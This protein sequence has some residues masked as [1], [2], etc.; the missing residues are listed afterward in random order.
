M[1]LLLIRWGWRKDNRLIFV[2]CLHGVCAL[3]CLGGRASKQAPDPPPVVI[4]WV[5]YPWAVG[6]EIGAVIFCLLSMA[7]VV[8]FI[9]CVTLLT[10]KIVW[11]LVGSYVLRTPYLLLVQSMMVNSVRVPPESLVKERLSFYS[12]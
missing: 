5:I 8:Y 12:V 10:R 1:Y 6:G 11:I 7:L 4:E 9:T 3:F 2:C